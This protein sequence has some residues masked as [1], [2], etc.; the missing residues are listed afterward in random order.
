MTVLSLLLGAA[1][2]ME[3]S[4]GVQ[5]MAVELMLEVRGDADCALVLLSDPLPAVAVLDADRGDAC[6][7]CALFLH[8]AGRGLHRAP[9]LHPLIHHQ[10]PHTWFD[11]VG[12]HFQNF[13][14]ARVVGVSR[15]LGLDAQMT[16]LPHSYE[17]LVEPSGDASS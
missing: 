9:G 16:F 12:A 11:H 7:A 2:L 6:D 10:H 15:A 13:P 17:A 8:Q 1:W 5:A 3:G 14:P 4:E